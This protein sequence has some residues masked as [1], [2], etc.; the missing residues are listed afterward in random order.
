MRSP[1]QVLVHLH[2]GWRWRTGDG[3]WSLSAGVDNLLGRDT[4]DTLRIN[5]AGGRYFEPAPGRTLA[6]ALH[7]QARPPAAP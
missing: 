2:G 6:L 7:W 3:L 4:L 1:G 5:A